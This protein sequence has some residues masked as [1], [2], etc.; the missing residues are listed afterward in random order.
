M[1]AMLIQSI[2]SYE[3]LTGSMGIALYFRLQSQMDFFVSESTRRCSFR[4][5]LITQ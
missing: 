2:R 3:K 1:R 4:S 5:V